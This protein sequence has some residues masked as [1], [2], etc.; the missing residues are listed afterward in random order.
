MPCNDCPLDQALAKTKSSKS[1]KKCCPSV[2]ETSCCKSDCQ[3]D[4]CTPAYLRLDKVRNGWS[5]VATTA[6]SILPT[7]CVGE[8]IGGIV[9]RANTP[10]AVPTGSIFDS[11]E[12]DENGVSLATCTT[13]LVNVDLNNAYFA[14]VFVNTHRYLNFE[15][16]GKEDQVVGWYVDTSSGQLQL[17]QALPEYN[18]LVSDN[19]A[20]LDSIATTDLT[21][22]QKKKLYNLNVLYKLSV[23]AIERVGGNPKEEGNICE[24]TDKCGQKW[25][26]A[27][28]RANSD[29][30]VADNNTA[31]T[32]V[33][34]RL[35]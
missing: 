34:V 2:C 18:L 20:Y 5:L 12:A 23:K 33:A 14:Y 26:V 8:N 6:D 19:R 4:C 31:F 7:T 30:S 3:P 11:S 29:Q 22:V 9:T 16:C 10:I 28:N 35:C 17:Y 27:I 32:V 1:S 24:F 21:S 25:L 13:G 15:A